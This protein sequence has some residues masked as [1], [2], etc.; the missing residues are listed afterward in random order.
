[1]PSFFYM[2]C[3]LR[4]IGIHVMLVKMGWERMKNSRGRCPKLAN[5]SPFFTFTSVCLVTL[6][7]W[8]IQT[9]QPTWSFLVT[10][11]PCPIGCEEGWRRW[12]FS[13]QGFIPFE[14]NGKWWSSALK[15]PNLCWPYLHRIFS[16]PH[17]H[18]TPKN[19]IPEY[20]AKCPFSQLFSLSL[21][22]PPAL[23]QCSKCFLFRPLEL[24]FTLLY[25][26][27]NVKFDFGTQKAEDPLSCGL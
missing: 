13:V 8:E 18:S 27:F 17:P 16:P 11:S 4:L 9:C 6:V 7:L 23:P 26:I 2:Q 1:M 22:A 14:G 15:A 19:S 12:T 10:G 3:R 20:R 24:A 5:P 25:I 21:S